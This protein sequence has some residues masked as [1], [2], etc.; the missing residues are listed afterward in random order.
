MGQMIVRN[1]PDTVHAALK[2]VAEQNQRSA[3][4]EL[5]LLITETYKERDDKGFGS[6]LAAKYSG[7]LEQGFEFKRDQT[8]TDPVTFE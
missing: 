4:A 3:E 6:K 2:R 1:I 5:R 7:V 8:S